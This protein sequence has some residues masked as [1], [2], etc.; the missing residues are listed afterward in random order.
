M[1]VD[2]TG[3]ANIKTLLI[4]QG[5]ALWKRK[6]TAVAVCWTICMLG[7]GAVW[8]LPNRYESDARAFIDVNGLLTPLLKGLV[9]ETPPSQSADYLRQTLLSRPNLEQVIYLADLASPGADEATREQ[10]VTD[11]ASD[12]VVRPDGPNLISLSYVNQKPVVAKNVVQALLTIFAER[13]TQSSRVEMDNARKFLDR[14]ISNYE[15]QL[16]AVEQRRADFRKRYADYFADSGLP[17]LQVL[18]QQIAQYQQ[19]YED[20][21]I[22]QKTLAAQMGAIPQVMS[23]DSTPTVSNSGAIVTAAPSVRLAQ[24]QRNLSALQLEDTDKHPDVVSAKR[25]V[26]ELQAQVAAHGGE[27]EGKIQ[28]PNPA[29]E[30][31]KMKYVDAETAVP[32]AKD[33]LDKVTAE[34]DR[35]RKLNGN[36]PDIEVKAKNVDRDYDLVKANY[37]ELV[38]RR[39]AAELSQAA[40]DQADRTQFR[41][42]DPP[43]VPIVPVFPNRPLLYSMIL[44]FG[45][46]GGIGV[47]LFLGQMKPTFGSVAHLRELGLPVI[48]A[49][50]YV[51]HAGVVPFLTTTA[52]R[53]FIASSICLFA[54]YGAL[55]MISTG[56]YR[57]IL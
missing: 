53:M 7:W 16:H 29:Y 14:Q 25:V 22:M 28:V 43:E 49:V 54:V 10:M 8:A 12:V 31:I 56:L 34:F 44:L 19:Q 51:R 37:D 46:A 48:G 47:P 35:V 9:V 33:R 30:T 6:W 32:L 23:V 11:L 52:A 41:I 39:E 3:V 38:K 45:L 55:M 42:V 15:G 13:A 36:I 2:R 21:Q 17:R 40:D 26:G 18:Q 5:I 4:E 27:A 1:T 20:A 24:A 57:G 50:A